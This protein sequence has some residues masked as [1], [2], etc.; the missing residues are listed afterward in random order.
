MLAV[1]AVLPCFAALGLA[2]K[3]A[4]VLS[5]FVLFPV[6][7]YPSHM[8]GHAKDAANCHVVCPCVSPASD[9]TIHK[10]F[11]PCDSAMV[12]ALSRDA[13]FQQVPSQAGVRNMSLYH[14]LCKRR[15]DFCHSDL[16]DG[17][18]QPVLSSSL[19]KHD[20]DTGAPVQTGARL[21]LAP[22][23]VAQSKVRLRV[24]GAVHPCLHA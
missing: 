1:T 12:L 17:P 23:S 4:F 11:N 19:S 2:K 14:Q 8:S 24:A 20:T 7:I 22:C 6:A 16:I 5:L 10:C 21:C 9:R 13:S 15:S 3:Q 18:F